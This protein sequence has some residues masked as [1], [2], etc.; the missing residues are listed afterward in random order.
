MNKELSQNEKV[1]GRIVKA[2]AQ[3]FSKFGFKKTTVDDIA[4][5]SLKGKSTIYYYFTGKEDIF[6]AVVEKEATTLKSRLAMVISEDINPQDKLKK[7]IT[8][9]IDSFKELL[10]LYQ[11]IRSEYLIHLPFIEKIRQ[12]YDKEEVMLIK[13]MLTEGVEQNLFELQD[14]DLAAESLSLILKGL[15]IPLLLEDDSFK[16]LEKQLD[17]ILYMLFHGI[18]KNN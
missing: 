3:I 2:A 13:M 5:E 15:E 14:V 7:Y 10:N 1:R 8:T 6:R 17:K 4:R 18:L 11:A 12:K 16:K 9:R